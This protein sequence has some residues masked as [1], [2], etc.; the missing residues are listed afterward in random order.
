MA[1]TAR[2]IQDAYV[3]FFNRA[4][5][6]GGFAYWTSYAGSISDLYATFAQQTEYTSVYGGKTAEQQITTVYQNLF[7]RAPDAEGL[8][9]WKPLVEA[10]TIT[11]ANLALTVNRGAQGTD[12]TALT[13]KIDA[14]IVTTDAAVAAN[15]PGQ[16]FTL[17]T[18]A[19]VFTGT[20]KAD[21]FNAD[22]TTVND[23]DTLSGGAG[24][25]TLNASLNANVTD[26]FTTAAIESV[27]FTAF[28]DRTVDAKSLAGVET[29]ST[30]GS[31]G[32]ITVNNLSSSAVALGFSGANTNSITANYA[33]GALSGVADAL[34][35]KTSTAAGVAV[36]VDAGFESVAIQNTGKSDI[37]TFT[38]PGVTSIKVTGSGSLDFANASID[39]TVT[40]NAGNF[41]GSITTGT[42]SATTGLVDADIVG[43]AAEG[44]LVIL[45][46][47]DDNIGFTGATSAATKSDT[48]KLGS[49][50]DKVVLN[51]AGTGPVYVFGEAGND[52]V[53]VATSALTASDLIDGGSGSDTVSMNVAGANALVLRGIEN[54]E[55]TS[56]A[57]GAITINSAD[58][59]LA[60]TAKTNN[61]AVNLIDLTAGST[62]DVVLETAASAAAAAVS[63]GF[64]STEASSTIDI[65]SGMTGALAL[66][67]ITNATVNYGA[68]SVLTGAIT[69]TDTT[70]DLTLNSTKGLTG[71]QAVAGNTIKNVTIAGQDAVTMGAFSST[72]LTSL[73]VT[74]AKAVTIASATASDKLAS[75]SIT[76][77]TDAVNVTGAIGQA[78]TTNLGSVTVTATKAVTDSGDLVAAKIG[79]VNVTSTG[80][81]ATAGA[82]GNNAATLAI[83]TIAVSAAKA[84]GTGAIGHANTVTLGDITVT[85]GTTATLGAVLGGTA[86]NVTVSGTKGTV[87]TG[88][89]AVKAIG[90]IS[91]T[92]TEGTLS[93]G[94]IAASNTNAGVVGGVSYTATKGD[95]DLDEIT[96]DKTMG[97]V[98][99]VSTAGKIA[100]ENTKTIEAAD[101]TGLTVNMT[102]KTTI[103]DTDASSLL[104]KNTGGNITASLTG[105]AATA[106][107]VVDYTAVTSGVVNLTT[108]SIGL[109]STITNVGTKGSAQTSTITLGKGTNAITVGGTVDTLNVTGGAGND[110]LIL[111]NSTGDISGGT[112]SM[113]GGTDTVNFAALDGVA[114]DTN[115]IAV[116]LGSTAVTLGTTSLAALNAAEYDG[117]KK[118]TSGYSFTLNDIEAIVGTDSADYIV[119]NAAG[120]T[121]TGGDGADKIYGGAAADVITAG[122]GSDT[123]VLTS[124]GRDTV[125][126]GGTAITSAGG[127]ADTI[128]GFAFGST[129]GDVLQF[130]STFLK[131]NTFNSGNITS[132]A[133]GTNN[134]M[135]ANDGDILVVTTALTGASGSAAIATLVGGTSGFSVAGNQ[136]V[137]IVAADGSDTYIWYVND[138]LDTTVTDVTGGDIVLI[139]TLSGTAAVTGYHASNFAATIAA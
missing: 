134:G 95:L 98:N 31:T 77:T 38:T 44:S 6:T 87:T 39:G 103:A 124:G 109:T 17:T 105:T 121:I 34:V 22:L 96:S 117:T 122:N 127:N 115:G 111:S 138:T 72:A 104:V 15:L 102:A 51:A 94:S 66:G 135:S 36:D 48:V 101:A 40:L 69:A 61:S 112:L 49:G 108:S 113:G 85:G 41:A 93:A 67:K 63:V 130:G 92:A 11:L 71:G 119:A 80:D 132:I 110:T 137:V 8:A 118:A 82:I 76:S 126:F 106:T 57:A 12:T 86:S 29:L 30:V 13:G 1:L 2:E 25:D 46:S 56:T 107:A 18:G 64:K 14:A 43:S 65:T 32:A 78:T 9:Y 45:G 91:V 4:A 28:G 75:V 52:T 90:N 24:V 19:D 74:G 50:N 26:K 21:T 20:D 58:G 35:V 136:D 114:S 47:G 55:L 53:S 37:N 81:A 33:A 54:L 131:A 116:N 59:A 84:A 128:T 10:G 5:D 73:N 125:I 88:D 120:T 16:T 129:T 123:I 133:S 97:T 83:G 60:V 27:N 3:T 89:I 99:I 62:V 42:V 100:M 70:T 68:A 139:G 7:N 79:N 23:G